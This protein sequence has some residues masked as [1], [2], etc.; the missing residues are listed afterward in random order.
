MGEQL[1]EIGKLVIAPH[2]GDEPEWHEEMGMVVDK[3]FDPIAKYF[4]WG[5]MFPDGQMTWGGNI[6]LEVIGWPI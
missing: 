2:R 6:A 4:L 5:I 1:P 3:W